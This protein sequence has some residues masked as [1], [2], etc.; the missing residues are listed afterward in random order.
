MRTPRLLAVTLFAAAVPLGAQS[1]LRSAP[2]TSAT[3]EVALS[4]PRVQGQPAP[5]PKKIRITYGQ[6]HARGRMVAG[7]LAADMDTVWR[8]GANT[9]TTL[10]TDVDLEVGGVAVPQGMYSL[11][12]QTS[13]SGEWKLIINKNTGHW[14]TAYDAAHDLARV[15]LAASDLHQPIESLSI[16]L[17]PGPDGAPSGDLRIIWGTRAF[18]TTWAVK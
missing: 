2:S 10:T 13:R 4:T 9:S 3:V 6:P 14:G 17:V 18:T 11:Y 7:A 5:T 15:P 1:N 8:L 16:T 12:A